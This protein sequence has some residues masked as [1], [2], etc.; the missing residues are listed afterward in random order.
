[1]SI[2]ILDE[3]KSSPALFDFNDISIDFL[4]DLRDGFVDWI[5]RLHPDSAI[6]F[7]GDSPLIDLYGEGKNGFGLSIPSPFLKM[8]ELPHNLVSVYGNEYWTY[9]CA[10]QIIGFGRVRFVTFSSEPISHG[11]FDSFITNR[12]DWAPSKLIKKWISSI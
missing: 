10:V 4:D 1:M 3:R 11:N 7:Y 5:V 2:S 8:I 12:L 9:T 6:D